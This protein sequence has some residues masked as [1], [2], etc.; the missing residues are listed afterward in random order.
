MLGVTCM[1]R[2]WGLSVTQMMSQLHSNV[3]FMGRSVK[4]VNSVDLLGVLL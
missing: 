2:L 3:R 1:A 4:F